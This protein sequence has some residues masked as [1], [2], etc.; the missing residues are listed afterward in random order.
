LKNP[1]RALSSLNF[2]LQDTAVRGDFICFAGAALISL[3]LRSEAFLAPLAFALVSLRVFF[4]VRD[5]SLSIVR[6]A[7]DI[8]FVIRWFLYVAY[9]RAMFVVS[10]ALLG[11]LLLGIALVLGNKLAGSKLLLLLPLLPRHL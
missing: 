9:P 10:F 5:S 3:L 1:G 4:S 2:A 7:C 8:C 6:G 11:C